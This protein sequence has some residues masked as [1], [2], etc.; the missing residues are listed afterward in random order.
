[1]HE[2]VLKLGRRTAEQVL[3]VLKSELKV[4]RFRRDLAST[5]DQQA[6]AKVALDLQRQLETKHVKVEVFSVTNMEKDD[7]K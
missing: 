5:E 3:K 2:I 7:G 6:I 4:A 1:M